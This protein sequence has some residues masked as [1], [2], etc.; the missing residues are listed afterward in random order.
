M[1]PVAIQIT[2]QVDPKKGETTITLEVEGRQITVIVLSDERREGIR[3]QLPSGLLIGEE[4][5]HGTNGELRQ[6]VRFPSEDACIRTSTL[7]EGAGWQN[8]HSH[9]ETRE[10]YV[11]REGRICF[12]ELDAD[13][14]LHGCIYG[15]GEVFVTTPG[16]AH[17]L[18]VFGGTVFLTTKFGGAIKDW[19]PSPELDARTKPL[20]EAHI[21]ERFPT[22]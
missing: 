2:R 13:G 5:Q 11:V 9:R 16:R 14:V 12:V 20:S 22:S 6:R 21:L 8:A 18:Y 17:S 15:P 19:E 10:Q 7:G 4:R 1:E 3:V